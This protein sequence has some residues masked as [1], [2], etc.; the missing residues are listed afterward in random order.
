[1]KFCLLR[2]K[3]FGK[4][5]SKFPITPFATPISVNS[6]TKVLSGSNTTLSAWKVMAVVVPGLRFRV[7]T[8]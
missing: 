1:M 4:E 8:L 3:T 5:V 6:N 7:T 2:K